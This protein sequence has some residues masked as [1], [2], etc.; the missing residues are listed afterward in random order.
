MPSGYTSDIYEGKEV[1]GKEFIIRCARAFGACIMMRDDSL[2]TP[3][4]EEFKPDTYHLDKIEEAKNDL[5]RYQKI[6]NEEIQKII[7]DDY[8]KR[9]EENKKYLQDT[10]DLK[11]RYEKVLSEVEKW[12]PPTP[13]HDNLKNYAIEQLASSIQWDCHTE[14][15]TQELTKMSVEEW[16]KFKIESCIKDIKYHTEKYE[17][18]VKRVNERNKWIKD[19]RD[20]LI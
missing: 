12:I 11:K 15:Y 1:S 9:V 4:P 3:I 18:E 19:L 10:L 6:H 8:V 7:D 17:E 5:A 13:E 20:S 14:H 16:K 2:D